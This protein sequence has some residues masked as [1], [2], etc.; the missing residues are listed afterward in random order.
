MLVTAAAPIASDVL[1]FLKVVLC[2]P[3]ME[4]YGQTESTGGGFQTDPEDKLS[5]HLGSLT[6]IME[7]KLEDI[8]EME[9]LSTDMDANGVPTPRGEVCFRGN[10]L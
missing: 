1:D 10:C 7:M 3:I 5:G 9:Y 2:C 8:P 4:C 6:A